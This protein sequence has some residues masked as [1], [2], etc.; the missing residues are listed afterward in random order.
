MKSV[1]HYMGTEIFPRVRI[2]TGPVPEHWDLV[3]IAS[4]LRPPLAPLPGLWL[5]GASYLFRY[6]GIECG[7]RI[8]LALGPV[9]LGVLTVLAYRI[10]D[11]LMPPVLRTRMQKKGWSASPVEAAYWKEKGWLDGKKPWKP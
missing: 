6:A 5:H 3:A 7:V 4:G 1:I 2:G 11:E 8:L 9:A 10:F